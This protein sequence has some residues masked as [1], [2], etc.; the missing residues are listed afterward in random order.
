[1][2]YRQL[3]QGERYVM[4]NMMHQGYSYREIGRALDRSVST[5]SRERTRNA[6]QRTTTDATERTRPPVRDGQEKPLPQ[7]EPIQS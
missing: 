4:A 1:M 6:T 3:T 2:G 5:I 7:E